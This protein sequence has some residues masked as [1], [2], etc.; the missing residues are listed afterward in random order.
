MGIFILACE[1][2]I[3]KLLLSAAVFLLAVF[4]VAGSVYAQAPFWSLNSTNSTLKGSWIDHSLLWN[5]SGGLSGYI[6]SFYNGSNWTDGNCGDYA[7]QPLCLPWGCSWQDNFC[8]G[9]AAACSNWPNATYC[10]YDAGCT[11]GGSFCN[12]TATACSSWPNSTYCGYDAGCTWNPAVMSTSVYNYT[13]TTNNKAT[14]TTPARTTTPP[15]W[16]TAYWWGGSEIGNYS[17][18][19]TDNAQYVNTNNPGGANYQPSIRF[20]ITINE[21]PSS[22][23][24]IY[25]LW[26]GYDNASSIGDTGTCYVGNYHTPGWEAISGNTPSSPGYLTINITSN[27]SYYVAAN[28]QFVVLC[29]GNNFDGGDIVFTDFINVTVNYNAAAANCSGTANTCGTYNASQTNCQRVKCNWNA[30]YCSGTHNACGTYNGSQT[31]CQRVL[32]TWGGQACYGT[33]NY[34]FKN[35]SW[36]S[37]TGTQNWSNVTKFVNIIAGATIKWRI[38]AFDTS[39]NLNMSSVFSYTTTSP[40]GVV[41]TAHTLSVRLNINNTANTVYIPGMGEQASAGISGQYSSPP[42]FYLASYSGGFLNG[43]AARNGQNLVVGSGAD[44]HYLQIEQNLTNSRIYLTATQGDWHAI[45]NRIFLIETG[46]FL[47][48]ISPSFAFPLDGLYPIM[49]LLKYQNIDLAGDLSLGKGQ[50]RLVIENKGLSGG[51]PVVEISK[52]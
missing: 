33:P 51:K 37:F 29:V 47:S 13:N 32:C 15:V 26:K 2:F 49:L 43:L 34:E 20:N 25:F 4:L 31:N 41:G 12:G 8:Y 22:I 5:S 17:N 30:D 19:K 9:T 45:D 50:H 40:G 24:W 16:T 1:I 27:P 35:D 52:G 48:Q 42:H 23:N 46:R 3:M 7:T 11:W 44:S 39:N 18:L 10:G 36:V 28:K 6:F 14:I 21:A 38:Y